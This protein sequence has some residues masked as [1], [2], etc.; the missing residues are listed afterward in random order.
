V[1]ALEAAAQAP[2]GKVNINT[3]TADQ[4]GKVPGISGDMAKATDYYE[5]SIEL[6]KNTRDY[7]Q[8]ARVYNNL[9]DRF[10]QDGEWKRAIETSR[11]AMNMPA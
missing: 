1:L 11:S 3:A 9:G 10:L 8:V 2:A 5:K 7:K 6:L 4:L